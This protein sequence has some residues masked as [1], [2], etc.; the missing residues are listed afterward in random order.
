[1][2]NSVAVDMNGFLSWLNWN[3]HSVESISLAQCW[4][5]SHMK[6]LT[7]RQYSFIIGRQG[8]RHSCL[9]Q[10]ASCH[11]VQVFVHF[12]WSGCFPKR[13]GFST[14]KGFRFASNLSHANSIPTGK[15]RARPCCCKPWHL[16]AGDGVSLPFTWKALLRNDGISHTFKPYLEICLSISYTET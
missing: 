13:D 8:A 3:F 2:L 7:G 4:C 10:I 11:E 9:S 12:V 16:L 15:Q 5:S 1:M 14:L 6:K